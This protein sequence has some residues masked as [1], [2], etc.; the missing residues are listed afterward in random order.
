[1]GR[2]CVLVCGCAAL[3][4]RAREV[5]TYMQRTCA[6]TEAQQPAGTALQQSAAYSSF[7]GSRPSSFLPGH[8][9]LFFED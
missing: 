8:F 6:V 4:A 3:R 5:R 2:Y 7:S 9:T 1:M